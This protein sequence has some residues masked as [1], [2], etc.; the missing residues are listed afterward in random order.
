MEHQ[1]IRAICQR[2]NCSAD[3][4]YA[5]LRHCD[6]PARMRVAGHKGSQRRQWCLDETL[7]L[8]WLVGMSQRDR[9][10][11]IAESEVR[12]LRRQQSL[13]G[14]KSVGAA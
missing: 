1:G 11:Y 8:A 4:F 13:A 2:L 9:L 10:R 6:L 5:Y 3:T 7:A 14:R 12:R